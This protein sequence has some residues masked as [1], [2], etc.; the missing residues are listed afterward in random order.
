MRH[1]FKVNFDHAPL[2]IRE[3]LRASHTP[4]SLPGEL[5][6]EGVF[7][8]SHRCYAKTLVR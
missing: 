3:L 4:P 1:L 8:K 6:R 2:L 5:P 7:D